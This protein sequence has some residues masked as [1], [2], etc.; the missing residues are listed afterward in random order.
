MSSALAAAVPAS[1]PSPAWSGFSVGP[2]T[3]HAYALCILA[4]IIAAVMLT[5]IRWKRRHAPEGSIWDIAIW[6]IPFGIVGGRLYHVF[7]SPD[8]YFGPGY[9]GHGDLLLIPQIWRGGLGIWGA[10][11]LGVVGA[12]IGCRRSGV[13]LTAFLD[14]AAPG[15]LLAQALGRW[16]N[17]FNQELF[18]RPTTLP[19]GLQI[20]PASPNFPTAYVA[21]TLFHPTFLYESLWD[22]AGV[23]L[24]LLLDR[25]FHFRRGRLFWLYAMYYTLGRFWIEMLRIDDAEQITFFG[26]TARLNVWTSVL[27]FLVSLVAFLLLSFIRRRSV[28]DSVLLRDGAAADIGAMDGGVPDD[29]GRAL[30][31]PEGQLRPRRRGSRGSAGEYG[32]ESAAAV[33]NAAVQNTDEDA[34]SVSDAG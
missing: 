23:A 16:G 25:R 30:A 17:Y 34:K 11:L 27:V 20:D 21:D 9:N 15:L 6:A 31:A 5:S 32:D 14:A 13:K 29:G 4:G 2:V 28:G 3:V 19:W 26:V 12:W 10:V 22:V 24:L 18:G 8:N 1:I 33:Q 7:S